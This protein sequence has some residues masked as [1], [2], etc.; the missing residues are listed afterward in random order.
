[1]PNNYVPILCPFPMKVLVWTSSAMCLLYVDIH[2]WDKITWIRQIFIS[3]ISYQQNTTWRIWKTL[4]ILKNHAAYAGFC[5]F[6]PTGNKKIYENTLNIQKYSVP[7][8][9]VAKNFHT[10]W[11]CC[12]ISWC[13]PWFTPPGTRHLKLPLPYDRKYLSMH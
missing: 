8:E 9:N 6:W 2:N 10:P 13:T 7:N 5:K 12:K 1:M 3:V 11:S 4:K